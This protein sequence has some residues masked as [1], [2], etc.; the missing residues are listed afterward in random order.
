MHNQFKAV[1]LSYKNA[2]VDVREMVAFD[3]AQSKRLLEMIEDYSDIS[4]ALIIST[5]NRTEVYYSSP[6]DRYE[7]IIKLIGIVKSISNISDYT[8]YFSNLSEHKQAVQHL[9]DVSIGLEAQVVGDLQIINQIK[10]AYQ[11]AADQNVVGPFLHRLLHTI[12]FTNKRVVQETAFRDGAASVSYA[13]VELINELTIAHEKP[14][15]L[16]LGLGEIGEDVVRNLEHIAEKEVVICNRSIEKANALAEEFGYAVTSFEGYEQAI[17]NADVIISSVRVNSPLITKSTFADHKVLSH[18]Y[19]FDLSMPRSIDPHIEEVNGL[20]LYN[21]DGIQAKA[22]EA[23]E[24][25]LAAIPDVKAIIAEAIEEFGSWS[26]EMEVSPVINKLKNALEEIRQKEIARHLKKAN[27]AEAEL[28]DKATKN[29]M[30][31]II[32]LPVLQL[33]AACQRGEADSLIEVLNDL[34]NLEEQSEKIKSK[35]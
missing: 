28:L 14:N 21:I 11:I 10:S 32:K 8:K 22:T 3:E 19:L 15:I 29:I 35:G 23:L 9:F 5:C 1:S 18:K 4:E 33:K 12:F 17:L 7:V 30:Q 26:K 6:S 2:P 20:L 34:F 16:V 25:R 27:E 31:K 24:R 13:T